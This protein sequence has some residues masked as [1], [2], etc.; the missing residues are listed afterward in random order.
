M[1]ETRNTNAQVP[2]PASGMKITVL[3]G[4]MVGV[5]VALEMQKRGADVTLLDR[6][7]PG[8]GTSFGNAGVLTRSSLFPINNPGLLRDLPGLLTNTRTS[9]R[10]D[11]RYLLSNLPWAS[12]FLLNARKE[13][14]EETTTAL[15]ALITLS[16]KKHRELIRICNQNSRL[17]EQGWV[18]LYRSASNYERAKLLRI[19]LEK[20][21]VD[22]LE[23]DQ[24]GLLDL[25]PDL[26]PIFPRALWIRDSC[27]VNDP[28]ALVK[29]YAQKFVSLGGKV[30]H[31]DAS[32]VS[33]DSS[34]VDISLADGKTLRADKL[35]VCLGPWSKNFLTKLGLSVPMG[36]ERGYHMHFTG[37]RDSANAGV[38]RRPIYDTQG[39]YVLSP[40]ASGLRLSTG[41]ELA[42]RAAPAST[43]QI[44]LAEKSAREAFSLGE[45]MD[46]DPWLGCRPT[47]PDSRP[48]IG[49]APAYKNISLAFGHQHIGLATGTGTAE[50]LADLI[51]GAAPPIDAR[52]FRPDRF[53]RRVR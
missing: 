28:A 51:E 53:I 49:P 33:E 8:S 43:V 10:F 44:D 27:S 1:R 30:L 14:F 29:A 15:D 7:E 26:S 39:G 47:F 4:G 9:F 34:G 2:Q 6:A 50:I 37:S 42:S 13:K 46:Q 31:G 17:S 3:G 36:Y 23:L 25:E 5:C 52:P 12:R 48:V 21:G 40:M 16:I 45:R 24:S 18:F 20:F 19:T 22:T 11:W 32:S 35:A 41:V 38:L